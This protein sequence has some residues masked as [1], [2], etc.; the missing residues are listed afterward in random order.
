MKKICRCKKGWKKR[1]CGFTI[2]YSFW[3]NIFLVYE[4][5]RYVIYLYINCRCGRSWIAG[6]VHPTRLGYTRPVDGPQLAWERPAITPPSPRHRP[7]IG[8]TLSLPHLENGLFITHTHNSNIFKPYCFH[9]LG[10]QHCVIVHTH[11]FGSNFLNIH[12]FT[13]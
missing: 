8:P 11:G 4:G 12:T 2:F 10:S 5:G 3:Q 6:R 13:K 1:N 7:A 9:T